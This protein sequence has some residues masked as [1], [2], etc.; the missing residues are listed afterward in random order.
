MKSAKFDKQIQT[1]ARLQKTRVVGSLPTVRRR[2]WSLPVDIGPYTEM[3]CLRW[4][5]LVT[6]ADLGCQAHPWNSLDKQWN[7][8][9][10]R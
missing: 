8:G 6:W 5:Q 10:Q 1:S 4:G 2:T 9:L 3:V 7:G